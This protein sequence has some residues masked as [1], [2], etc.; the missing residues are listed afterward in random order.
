MRSSLI[1]LHTV[2]KKKKIHRDNFIAN[3][4]KRRCTSQ[5]KKKIHT[6]LFLFWRFCCRLKSNNSKFVES[7][8]AKCRNVLYT[9]CVRFIWFSRATYCSN[10][11]IC[12]TIRTAGIR[13]AD[14][15]SCFLPT[16]SWTL[17]TGIYKN[18]PGTRWLILR[19]SCKLTATSGKRLCD[20]LENSYRSTYA[21]G[22]ISLPSLLPAN[23]CSYGQVLKPYIFIH[24]VDGQWI[25]IF[26]NT[27]SAVNVNLRR[28]KTRRI[29]SGI[30]THTLPT[31]FVNISLEESTTWKYIREVSRV[32]GGDF[33]RSRRSGDSTLSV[34]LRSQFFASFLQQFTT[35]YSKFPNPYFQRNRVINVDHMWQVVNVVRDSDTITSIKVILRAN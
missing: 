1:D 12:L 35:K 16:T 20:K 28:F 27:A 9:V 23:I 30:S 25:T 5:K 2:I 18:K 4:F 29:T 3:M 21:S 33:M 11:A 8:C 15:N 34:R 14:N 31:P 26:K 6:Q 22:T 17:R 32:V 19:Q 10:K 24:A 13:H 7:K